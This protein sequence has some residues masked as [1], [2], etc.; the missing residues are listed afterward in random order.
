M[1]GVYVYMEQAHVEE[2]QKEF[3][4]LLQTTAT[5]PLAANP[6]E[7]VW[8]DKSRATDKWI[9]RCIGTT[10]QLEALQKAGSAVLIQ[11]PTEA[12]GGYKSTQSTKARHCP[13]P[14]HCNLF[15]CPEDVGSLGGEV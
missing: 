7:L 4:E 8:M 3:T 6:N 2:L 15:E 10:A 9:L 11:Y 14:R 1:P 13:I 5:F 12:S